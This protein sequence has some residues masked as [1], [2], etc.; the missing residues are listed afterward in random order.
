MNEHDSNLPGINSVK[1]TVASV[2]SDK[3]NKAVIC[4][5]EHSIE[6]IQKEDFQEV[7]KILNGNTLKVHVRKKSKTL[8]KNLTRRSGHM[9]VR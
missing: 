1:M 5:E 7:R 9:E 8:N 4:G 2:M 6:V 3:P